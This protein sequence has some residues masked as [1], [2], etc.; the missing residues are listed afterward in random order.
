MPVKEY[1]N[2]L[3]NE[4]SPYLLQHAHN[5]V[6]WYPWG[7]EAFAKAKAEDKPVFLSIGYSTCH[8][9]HVMERES[10]EDRETAEFLNGNF[11]CIKVDREER[12]DVDAYYMD[13]CQTL[14]GTGGWPLSC[15]LSHDRKP[16]FAGTYFPKDGGIYGTGFLSVLTQIDRI[17]RTRKSDLLRSA[18]EISRHAGRQSERENVKPGRTDAAFHQLE[19]RFDKEYGGFGT[20]PKF[21]SPQI[22]LFL[23]RYGFERKNREAYDMVRKTL[24]GMARGGIRDHIGGGFSRYSTDE[25]WLIPHFEKMMADNALHILV[26]SEAAAL[27]GEKYAAVAKDTARFCLREMHDPAGG[28]YTA[29]DAD[30]EGAEGKYYT[31]S[32]DEII[33]VLGGKDGRRYCALFHITGQGNFEGKNVPNRIGAELP[34]DEIPF[35]KQCGERLLE[36][37]RGRIPPRKDDKVTANVNGLMT[38]ALAA[39][40]RILGDAAFVDAA[41]RC[42]SF[43]L[44]ELV[45]DGRLLNRWRAGESGIPANSDDYA[46]L[47]WGLIELYEATFHPEWL[48][49]AV[50]FTDK[51]DSLFRD[52]D[53]YGY[54]LTGI[55]VHDLPAR[56]KSV[57]DGALPSGNAIMALN[58]LRLSRLCANENY[59]TAANRVIESAGTLLNSQPSSCCGLLCSLLFLENGG[60]EVVLVNGEGFAPLCESLPPFSPFLSAAAC[61]KGFETIFSSAPYLRD[62]SARNGK[63]AAYV[64]RNGSCQ[65]AVTAAVELEK[66]LS[67]G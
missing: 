23:M 64:C 27:F 46:C 10:F 33:R 50:L 41:E 1:T 4:K 37:R 12:P 32:P 44:S 65:K 55:D 2:R 28:F 53:G 19:R 35:A 21:P 58:L 39:A 43:M 3:V 56:Q 8:W 6:D 59:V 30:S 7:D 38:A 51:M 17:W 20:A 26:Y 36:Y 67:D 48:E 11:V 54:Y 13:A 22:L 49:Q 62:Y 61:G 60:T 63:A 52:P 31:F 16:F 24:D 15:F 47:I 57:Y 40:G 9:C 45:K 66:I 5:P 25:K 18:R 42:A 34:E 14:T 29:V